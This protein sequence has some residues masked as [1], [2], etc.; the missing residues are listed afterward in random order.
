M[1]KI[2][3]T[4]FGTII[5]ALT[6]EHKYEIKEPAGLPTEERSNTS[7]LVYTQCLHRP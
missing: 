4:V 6:G 3:G 7:C 2:G 1:R 5:P